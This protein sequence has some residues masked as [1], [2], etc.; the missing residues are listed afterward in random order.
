MSRS[1]SQIDTTSDVGIKVERLENEV[2]ALTEQQQ[3]NTSNIQHLFDMASTNQKDLSDF[4]RKLED[5][6]ITK[7]ADKSISKKSKVIK[8]PKRSPL[9][10]ALRIKE[11]H[12][13]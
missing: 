4:E 9:P 7:L 10:L 2:K 1:D 6:G 5:G 3:Q 8:K 11:V 12:R 13:L